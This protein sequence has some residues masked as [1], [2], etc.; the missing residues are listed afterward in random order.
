MS[1][2]M[3]IAFLYCYSPRGLLGMITSRGDRHCGVARA[4]GKTQAAQS[5]PEG[6]SRASHYSI[7][8]ITASTR[9]LPV[10]GWIAPAS[11]QPAYPRVQGEGI[12]GSATAPSTD[13]QPC[14]GP[15]SSANLHVV[16]FY[17]H[18]PPGADRTMKSVSKTA[19]IGRSEPNTRRAARVPARH[20]GLC[21]GASSATLLIAP[22]TFIVVAAP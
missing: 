4:S 12:R 11:A 22:N 2:R 15:V 20:P 19:T 9:R 1:L 21:S 18:R 14:L 6:Q 13:H 17:S 16:L 5:A 10:K 3:Y 7:A 8:C